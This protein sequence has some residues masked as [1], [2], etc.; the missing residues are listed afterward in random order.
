MATRYRSVEKK[1]PTLRTGKDGAERGDITEMGGIKSDASRC[2]TFIS[3]MNSDHSP[4]SSGFTL[5]L[6]RPR[7]KQIK[8]LLRNALV[9]LLPILG[10]CAENSVDVERAPQYLKLRGCWGQWAST[11]GDVSVTLSGPDIDTIRADV[12]YERNYLW[13]GTPGREYFVELRTIP[14]L[15]GELLYRD[16]VV[17]SSFPGLNNC[18]RGDCIPIHWIECL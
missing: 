10:A 4:N 13:E 6:S 2:R 8:T 3:T 12:P 7:P 11:A 16:T 17:A 18:D 1:E 5:A 9:L 14:T 15:G